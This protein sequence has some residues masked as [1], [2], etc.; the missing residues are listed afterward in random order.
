M[1]VNSKRSSN[2]N[3]GMNYR[4]VATGVQKIQ[5]YMGQ[6]S[7]GVNKIQRSF[8]N[9][10]LSIGAA[11]SI[12]QIGRFTEEAINLALQAEGVEKAFNKMANAGDLE[13]LREATRN[14]VSDLELMRQ[15][16]FARSVGI[17]M[18][19]LAKVMAYVQ[20]YSAATGKAMSELMNDATLE[21]IRQTGLRLDNIGLNLDTVKKRAK[22]IG[23]I[24]AMIE[25]ME[26]NA[27]KF[28]DETQTVSEKVQQMEAAWENSKTSFG[29]TVMPVY[30]KGLKLL[31]DG[32]DAI[33]ARFRFG[34]GASAEMI[35]KGK[36]AAKDIAE[37]TQALK[38]KGVPDLLIGAQL[39]GQISEAEKELAEAKEAQEGVTTAEETRQVILL[40]YK[41]EALRKEYK[42]LHE[43]KVNP[44]GGGGGGGGGGNGSS[45]GVQTISDIDKAVRDYQ[46][47]IASNI[48]RAE[49]GNAGTAGVAGYIAKAQI[50]NRT[51]AYR[52]QLTAEAQ[53][54]EDMIALKAQAAPYSANIKNSMSGLTWGSSQY[55]AVVNALSK[56]AGGGSGVLMRAY[57]GYVPG[58]KSSG[59]PTMLHGGEYVLNAKAVQNMGRAALDTI[60]NTRFNT[61]SGVSGQ[62]AVTTV[63]KT[64]NINIYV[65]N[66]I[67]EER[68][69]ESMMD[70]YNVKVKPIKEKSRGEEARVFSSYNYRTGR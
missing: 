33:S 5:G 68:W 12:Q 55:A 9:L 25:S 53:R 30:L 58:F 44:T 14:L 16:N 10:G 8:G 4:G 38:E 18:E 50:E 17:E 46:N 63:N 23:F 39:L 65:D 70:T 6:M 26:T 20:R 59:I 35:E 31:S 36:D 29:E 52:R 54:A 62:G 27:K 2:I 32:L 22:E 51:E 47:S 42:K 56:P 40:T 3:V 13:K 67:G 43:V 15:A 41:L 61:P 34:Y 21:M 24:P 19:D 1:A 45:P 66:F 64:E 48:V 49:F 60:N 11:F 37:F 69:F 57:G 28:G 7:R